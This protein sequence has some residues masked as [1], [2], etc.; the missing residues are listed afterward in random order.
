MESGQGNRVETRAERIRR[1]LGIEPGEPRRQ[2]TDEELH[3]VS[4]IRQKV[5]SDQNVISESLRAVILVNAPDVIANLLEFATGAKGPAKVQADV[6][7][8]WLDRASGG[9][10]DGPNGKPLAELPL[11]QLETVLS[12]T[13]EATRQLRSLNG[14]SHR[15][16]STEDDAPKSGAAVEGEPIA[17][18]P[19]EAAPG[20]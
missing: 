7:I 18:L 15:I 17:D 12:S 19:A 20:S 1:M 6:G 5:L 16:D 11:D 13:L 3:Q 8:W 4:A 2:P 9:K 10:L 14:E